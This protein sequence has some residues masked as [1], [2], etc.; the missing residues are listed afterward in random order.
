M[1]MNKIVRIIFRLDVS[2]YGTVCFHRR[3][4]IH[5][6]NFPTCRVEQ[7]GSFHCKQTVFKLVAHI[8]HITF[9]F[10]DNFI[11]VCIRK[12]LVTE[13]VSQYTDNNERENEYIQ[14]KT[15]E[16]CLMLLLISNSFC[17]T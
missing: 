12:H 6:S 1:V 13:Q 8:S 11:T 7:T 5:R 3:W 16:I 10:N 14:D 9:A 2:T 15:K 4:G 17:I